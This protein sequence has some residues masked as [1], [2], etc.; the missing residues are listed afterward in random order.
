MNRRNRLDRFYLDDYFPADDYIRS[1]AYIE[2]DGLPN[3]RPWLLCYNTKPTLRHL[4][5]QDFFIN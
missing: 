2:P 4:M 3:N 5:F 1:E